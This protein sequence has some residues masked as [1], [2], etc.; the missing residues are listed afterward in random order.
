[1]SRVA[2]HLSVAAYVLLVAIGPG[3]AHS[4]AQPD[5]T[6]PVSP[7]QLAVTYQ[8]VLEDYSVVNANGTTSR[9]EL[10]GAT[11]EYAYR[12]YYPFQLVGRAS[13]ALGQPPV[14]QHLTS[15]TAGLGYTRLIHH[16]YRPFTE[17]TAGTAHTSSPAHQYLYNS[18][19]TGLGMALS[20]GL[21]IDVSRSFGVRAIEAQ[22]KH[23]PF[24]I[25][26]LGS[27][28][29]SIGAGAYL[30]FGK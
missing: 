24:G 19:N 17:F 1:M 29:W 6:Y 21:D 11:A 20:G 22:E 4:Q 12:H 7:S 9:V 16:L 30:R 15:F 8:R 13:Y 28:Y 23:L 5:A 27:V 26:H 18:G 14:N 3:L 10:N 2:R 25:N